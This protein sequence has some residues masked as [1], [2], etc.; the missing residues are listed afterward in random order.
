VKSLVDNVASS[1]RFEV[2]KGLSVYVET[3]KHKILFDM[4]VKGGAFLHNAEKM[5]VNIANID[6]AVISHGHYDHGGGLAEFLEANKT[7]KVFVHRRAF[8]KHSAIFKIFDIGL[9]SKLASNDRIVLT[10]GPKYEIDKNVV[11]FSGVTGT[12]F[13]PKE[14]KRLLMYENGTTVPDN[15][16]HE[17][18]LLVTDDQSGTSLLLGGCAHSGIQ[19]ILDHA[20]TLG[21]PTPTH[22]VSGFHLTSPLTGKGEDPKMVRELATS[23][24]LSEAKFYTGHCTGVGSYEVLK[25]VM[26][27]HIDYLSAGMELTLG[28]NPPATASLL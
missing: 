5:G 9:N 16:A 12:K 21:L 25:E 23:L 10:D 8:E 22:V 28:A 4:G 18:N 7:A 6:F 3:S 13:Y 17:Q 14:N 24:L 26:G 15:F 1:K 19:N 11:L 2:Q 27:D 20:A